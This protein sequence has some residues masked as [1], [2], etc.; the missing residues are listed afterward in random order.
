MPSVSVIMSVYNGEAY[1]DASIRSILS[2]TYT[3]FEFIIVDDGSVDNTLNI[4]RRHAENDRRIVLSSRENKGL[5][6]SLNE[7][8]ELSTGDF[9]ARMDADDIAFPNRFEEQIDAFERSDKCIALGSFANEINSNGKD[10][11][12]LISAPVGSEAIRK[13]IQDGHS[14]VIHPTLMMKRSSFE[15]IGGYR[16]HFKHAEDKDLLYRL[17]ELGEVDNLPV[18][19]LQY[20]I[21]GKNVSVIHGNY[22]E[23]LGALIAEMH[24]IRTTEGE[25]IS[26]YLTY[27]PDLSSLDEQFNR[28]G[29]RESVII[30]MMNPYYVGNSYASDP[31]SFEIIMEGLAMMDRSGDRSMIAKATDLKIRI[32]KSLIKQGNFAQLL[33]FSFKILPRAARLKR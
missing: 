12:R 26:K 10:M 29:L 32:V 9:L 25:D 4:I 24:K 18:P 1:L 14:L 2:Q 16:E 21:H 23:M 20:R 8:A 3:D 6:A 22:Q 5:I 11:E 15:S 30:R 19:L 28:K 27:P 13:A 17:V 33:R 7:A 31:E